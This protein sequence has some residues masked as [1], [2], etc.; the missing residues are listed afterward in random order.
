MRQRA[1]TILEVTVVT[2]L[3][4]LLLALTVKFVLPAMRLSLRT[5]YR[6]QMQQACYI[7]LNKIRTDLEQTN[8]SA[9]GFVNKGGAES[10]TIVAI[11]PL[12]DEV[13]NSRPAYLQE[14]IVYEWKGSQDKLMRKVWKP[15]PDILPMLTDDPVPKAITTPLFKTT[16]PTRLTR[17]QLHQVLTLPQSA[18]PYD[19]RQICPDVID[20]SISSAIAPP[21]IENPIRLK[22][23]L[24]RQEDSCTLEQTVYLRNSP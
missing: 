20:F 13:P 24:K 22:L 7:T 12:Q 1:F 8:A 5:Q 10:D 21:N 19:S 17:A 4:F 16:E 3:A 18:P 15:A 9:I 2:A 23:T 14:L 11:Q 6:T